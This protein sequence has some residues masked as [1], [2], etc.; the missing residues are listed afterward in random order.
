MNKTLRLFVPIF[1]SVLVFSIFIPSAFADSA[2]ITQIVFIASPQAIVANAISTVFTTETQNTGNTKEDVSTTTILNLVSTSKT[3]E[4]SASSTDWTSITALTMAS[5]TA[6]RNFFYLDSTPGTYTLTV[7]ASG[8]GLTDSIATSTAITITA[9]LT[10]VAITGTPQVGQTLTAGSLMPSSATANYKWQE[11]STSNGTYTAISGATSSSYTPVASDVNQY[12]EVVATGTGYY[13]S[14]AIS[15]PTTVVTAAAPTG[16]GETQTPTPTITSTPTAGDT[17]VSGTAV[18]SAN[19]SLT[20]NS[21]TPTATTTDTNDNWIVTGLALAEGDVIS[22]TAQV[23]GDATSTATTTTVAAASSG[24]ENNNTTSTTTISISN[25]QPNWNATGGGVYSA[26]YGPPDYNA[27]TPGSTAVYDSRSAA[28]I[29]AGITASSTGDY[30]DQGLLAFNPNISLADFANMPLTYDFVNQSGSNPVWAY[31][32]IVPDGTTYN[33]SGFES[34][35]TIPDGYEFFQFVPVANPNPTSW[36]NID[37][38]DGEW[39]QWS[40]M[41]GYLVATSSPMTL[42]QIAAAYPDYTV[43]RVYLA[44]GMGDSYNNNGTGTVA[45]VDTATI[46]GTTYDFT[47]A[48]QNLNLS[49]LTAELVIAQNDVDDAVVGTVYGDYSQSSV[50][51]LSAAIVM[52]EN[53]AENTSDNTQTAVD[54][55]FSALSSAVARFQ[56]NAVPKTTATVVI[57]NDSQTYTGLPESVTTETTP[58]GL[59]VNVT[60]NGSTSAPTD[61]G[62]YAVVATIADSNYTGSASDTLVITP[63]PVTVTFYASAGRTDYFSKI[64]D[65][66]T[67]VPHYVL[68]VVDSVAGDSVSASC[69]STSFASP[70]VGDEIPV[71]ASGC[72]LSGAQAEDYSLSNT[73]IAN[74][75]TIMAFP[76]TIFANEPYGSTAVLDG[77]SEFNTGGA[78]LPNGET[79]GSVTLNSN[80]AAANAPVGSYNI[81]PSNAT[82]GTFNASNYNIAY[83][84]GNLTVIPATPIITW[85]NPSNIIY[86]TALNAAQLDATVNNIPGTFAYTP[87]SGTV[88]NAG[89]NQT[90]SVTFTPTDTT[91][92]TSA[93]QTATITVNQMPIRGRAPPI[94][95]GTPSDFFAEATSANGAIVTYAMPTATDNAGNA[96]AV[97]CAPV[98]GSVFALGTITVTCTTTDAA[99]NIAIPTTFNVTVRDTTAPVITLNGDSTIYLAINNPFVDPGAT[100]TDVV[101]GTDTVMVGGIVNTAVAGTYILSYNATDAAGNQAKT[102]VRAVTI[103]SAALPLPTTFSGGGTTLFGTVSNATEASTTSGGITATLNIP[104]ETTITGSSDWDGTLTLPTATTATITIPGFNTPVISAIAIGSNASDLTLS[105]PVQLTFAGQHGELVGWYNYNGSAFT[106]ITDVCDGVNA[107][108]INGTPIIAPNGTCMFDDGTNII[109]WTTHFSTFVTYTK[110]AISTLVVNSGGGSGGGAIV[111][112][113]GAPN[114]LPGA[115]ATTGVITSTTTTTATSSQGQVLGAEAYNFAKNLTVSSRGA[116]VIALQRFLINSGYSIPAG[117]TGYFGSQT[118]TAVIAYQKANNLP[119]TGVVGSLTRALL[120][121]GEVPTSSEL[122]PTEAKSIVAILQ[123]FGVDQTTLA[124][125]RAAL[126]L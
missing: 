54:N 19:I 52:A 44:E 94:I 108:T 47:A 117:A 126:G 26:Y 70:N 122:T 45:Y 100:A 20:I 99:G 9:P 23:A 98:S 15:S 34:A 62:S 7:T 112:G 3:G 1:F 82:G 68:S 76:F 28:P 96:D 67:S 46:G 2:D 59:A 57:T 38:G 43:A 116:D 75:G 73:T 114:P 119:T 27:V 13:T 33:S 84:P 101:D 60:Y 111:S 30:D 5:S 104:S 92:Y 6:R 107:P 18:A 88:L 31:I 79:I 48:G 51:T 58:A 22:V 61:A 90:L 105:Q 89:G 36:D 56:E 16:G 109:V 125:V 106:Q 11:A 80:G 50:D 77:S 29:S 71:T 103:E 64:Y 87:A 86:G 124:K 113:S 66:T 120:N 14:S 78:D 37:A 39:L 83:Y 102:A 121:K 53:A 69:R 24:N 42:T 97:S 4:F 49:A 35:G 95:S 32:A 40:N 110:T 85:A 63:K 8:S 55:A 25:L 81:I 65:G 93:T 118:K 17:S 72:S 21:G 10:A 12:I 91:D 123:S 41:N 74:T 115:V